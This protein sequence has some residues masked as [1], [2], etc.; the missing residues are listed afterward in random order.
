MKEN[1]FKNKLAGVGV[2]LIIVIQAIVLALFQMSISAFAEDNNFYRTDEIG[3][4][5]V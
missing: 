3:R 2:V 1:A 4:A 5:H